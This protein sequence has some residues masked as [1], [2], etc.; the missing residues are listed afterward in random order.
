MNNSIIIIPTYNE[1]ENIPLLADKLRQSVDGTCDVLIMDDSPNTYTIAAAHQQGWEACWRTW[2]NREKGLSPAVI[3][4]IKMAVNE[5]KEQIIV[6]DADL[7]HPP[8]TVAFILRALKDYDF[9]VAS[10]YVAGAGIREWSFKRRVISKVA[11]WLAMPLMEFKVH[12]MMSGFFGFRVEKLPE[13]DSL[14]PKGY[15]IGT[16]LLVKGNWSNVLEIPYTFGTREAG[17]SKLS[18]TQIAEYLKQL[19]NL[20][21]YKFRFLKFGL[22]GLSG[23]FVNLIL[24]W[25]F[26]DVVSLHY[27]TSASLAFLASV[28]NNYA[29]NYKWTFRDKIAG[30]FSG[31]FKY[32]IM[33]VAT[34][35]VYL[36]ALAFMYEVLGF[37]YILAAIIAI[38]I[39]FAIRYV[40][41][42][43]YIWKE[44]TA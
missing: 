36:G 20:Y 31:W 1:A 30:L 11:N 24:L 35:V 17:E 2:C 26:V 37:W 3:D 9:V 6:M 25:F 16:E 32:L 38:L 22:V 42:N 10:R 40:I 19:V 13:L 43:S 27:L 14:K 39:T 21:L 41:A 28:T 34:W 29:W 4:G 18:S 5:G 12:D 33:G 7:Q 15:K 23:I 8:R 44:K